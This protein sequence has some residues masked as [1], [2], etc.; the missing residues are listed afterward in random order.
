MAKEAAAPAAEAPQAEPINMI[1]AETAQDRYPLGSIQHKAEEQ[2]QEAAQD[3]AE[4]EFRGDEGEDEGDDVDVEEEQPRDEKGRFR[5]QSQML[6]ERIAAEARERQAERQRADRL[7]AM[8]AQVLGANGQP[9]QAQMQPQAPMGPPNPDDYPAGQFDPAYIQAAM[10]YRVEQALEARERQA[11]HARQQEYLVAAEQQFAQAVP[12]YIEAKQ[13]LLMDPM[14]ANHPGIG[15]AIMASKNPAPLL[16]A[17]GKN[18]EVASNIARMNPIQAAVAIGR[19]EAYI[20]SQLQQQGPQSPARA[21]PAP[22][23]PIGSGTRGAGNSDPLKAQSFAEFKRLRE[24]QES[25]R[26]GKR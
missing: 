16:Y 4:E 11:A 12:D 8:L 6:R 10:D 14:I 19:V 9:D 7:E 17:L 20:E 2:A 26:M 15:Q 24:E 3:A 13:A 22:I 21:A 23:K 1:V 25:K 5:S 18:I